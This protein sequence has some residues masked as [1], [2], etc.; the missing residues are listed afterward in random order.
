MENIPMAFVFVSSFH[1]GS[2]NLDIYLV[3]D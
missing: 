1:Y 3:L 2:Y